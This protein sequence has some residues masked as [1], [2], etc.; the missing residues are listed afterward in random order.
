V[1]HHGEWD[2]VSPILPIWKRA[3]TIPLYT[4]VLRFGRDGAGREGSNE[5]V[6]PVLSAIR[7]Y[8]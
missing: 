3:L 1:R 4:F 5:G 8:A 6:G 2:A 7:K